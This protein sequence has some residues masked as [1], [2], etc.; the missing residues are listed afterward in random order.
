MK[1]T[2][3]ISRAEGSASAADKPP[4]YSAHRIDG[5]GLF[6][7]RYINKE[8]GYGL[9][10][11]QDLPTGTLIFKERMLVYRENLD[12]FASVSEF[13]LSLGEEVKAM[14]PEFSRGFFT[15]PTTSKDRY[16]I[17][18]GILEG[19]KLSALHQ[20]KNIAMV[21]LNL[22]F[23]NHACVPNAQ[24]TWIQPNFAGNEPDDQYHKV[25]LYACKHISAGDEITI[26]Y[27]F[28]YMQ[29]PLRREF[30]SSLF[31][32]ECACNNCIHEV[33]NFEK[34]L[35]L[36]NE[37]LRYIEKEEMFH[38]HPAGMLQLAFTV[39]SLMEKCGIFDSRL[40]RLFEHC[41]TIAAWH[42]DQGRAME[43]LAK[44]QTTFVNLEGS[45]G[46]DLI[47]IANYQRDIRTIPEFGRTKRGLSKRSE[48]KILWLNPDKQFDMLFMRDLG[49]S[50]CKRLRNY[51][52]VRGKEPSYYDEDDEEAETEHGSQCGQ[53][54][55]QT[56]RAVLESERESNLNSLIED[57]SLEKGE[58]DKERRQNQTDA[59]KKSKG[60]KGRKAKK[61]KAK[62]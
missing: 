9:V 18:G 45:Q 35:S 50:D 58:Y 61:S 3:K 57:L 39:G 27:Y 26:A 6:A 16:G 31:G 47:K 59:G 12:S 10:A 37:Q 54:P 42:S 15:L 40:A 8:K 24:H 46:P 44:A 21:G 41:A 30:T 28:M 55:H 23:I 5:N 60:T 11:T 62:A 43:F 20:G 22:A 34:Y 4:P 53:E 36:I 56:E 14:G 25:T 17:L 2:E 52:G 33:E 32:F 1:R 51:E 48:V 49:R 7:V 13:N 19:S 38:N 29:L